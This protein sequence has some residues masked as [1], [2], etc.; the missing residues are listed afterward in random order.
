MAKAHRPYLISAA[1]VAILAFFAVPMLANTTSPRSSALSE[2]RCYCEC[3]RHGMICAK[4]M[5]D[6]PKYEKRWWATSCHKREVAPSASQVP[7]YQPK[8]DSHTRE[9]LNAKR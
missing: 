3:E 7:A 1:A 6:L 2:F 4:K 5:C 8:D 9:M